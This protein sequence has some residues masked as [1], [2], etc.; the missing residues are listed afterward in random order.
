MTQLTF[1][2]TSNR[3]R[4]STA[5]G[6]PAPIQ[7]HDILGQ[8]GYHLMLDHRADAYDHGSTHHIAT[9]VFYSLRGQWKESTAAEDSQSL[10]H[11][12]TEYKQGKSL[13]TVQDCV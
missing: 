1:H 13:R 9:I 3:I 7:D 4:R 2:K 12:Q 11:D 6:D 5:N 10:A 8:Y